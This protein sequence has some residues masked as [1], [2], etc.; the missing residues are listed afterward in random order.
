MQKG[1]LGF[2]L[3]RLPV[4]D[5]NQENI[6]IEKLKE[7][8]D[9]FLEGGFRY[10]DTSHVYHGGASQSAI[11]MALTD[12]YSRDKYLLA[13]KLPD[14]HITAEEQVEQIFAEQLKQCGVDYF[15]YY[16]IHNVNEL[17]YEEPVTKFHMFEHELEWKKQGKI[18]NLGLSFHDSAEVLDRILSEH[19]EVDFV[20]IVVNYYDWESTFIQS[21]KCYETIRKHGKELVIMQPVKA[22]TLAKVPDEILN[23]MM[24]YRPKISPAAWAL[25]FVNQLEGV[26]ATLSGMSNI[27]QIGDNVK[28]MQQIIPLSE[29]ERM[30]IADAVLSYKKNWKYAS[31]HWKKL[32]EA[33]PKHIPISSVIA[34]YNSVLMQPNPFGGAELNYYGNAMKR[35]CSPAECNHC[36]KCS[37]IEK[38]F[39]VEAVLEEAA[40]YLTDHAFS[41]SHPAYEWEKPADHDSH[42]L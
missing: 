31:E 38:A 23:K 8:V 39:D 1:K 41:E 27:D 6:D 30:V 32:D 33:C 25:T 10:F 42:C 9:A 13:T 7:M 11:K 4:I 18:K 16:L 36:G 37:K 40:K 15:D 22:G 35:V 24:S 14:F 2:G 26:I 28:A 17:L 5:N 19:P 34:N 29:E 20:Q 21:R 3:M 12:R